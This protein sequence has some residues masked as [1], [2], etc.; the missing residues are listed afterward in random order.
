M[1]LLWINRTLTLMDKKEIIN[2]VGEQTQ[3]I[4]FHKYNIDVIL[5][6]P[7]NIGSLTSKQSF[8][9]ILY[10]YLI[11]HFKQFKTSNTSLIYA[12][13]TNPPKEIEN[14]KKPMLY[15]LPLGIL[16]DTH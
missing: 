1:S 7:L 5:N 12:W 11:M 6:D 15:F 4:F 16:H 2:K 9:M 13:K 10:P 3:H 14:T 8:L